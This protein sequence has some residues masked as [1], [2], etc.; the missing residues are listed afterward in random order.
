MWP[1]R[2]NLYSYGGYNL[3]FT[4]EY[5]VRYRYSGRMNFIY[6]NTRILNNSR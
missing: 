6:Q 1:F 3:Y 5:R 4:P 2:A